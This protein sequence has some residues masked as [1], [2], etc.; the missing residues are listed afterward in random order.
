MLLNTIRTIII[1]NASHTIAK[2]KFC[3]ISSLFEIS[4]FQYILESIYP[5]VSFFFSRFSFFLAAAE[6]PANGGKRVLII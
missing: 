1:G 5:V 2:Q 6:K 3:K 4:T